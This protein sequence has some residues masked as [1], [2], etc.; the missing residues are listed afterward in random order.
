MK[1][2]GNTVGVLGCGI[3]ICYPPENKNLF[4]RMGEEGAIVTEYMPGEQPLPFHFPERNRIIAGLSKGIL[5]IEASQRSGSL[6]TARLGLEYGREVMAIPGSVFNE[7]YRGANKLIKEGA[8]L[9]D[10]IEDILTT[11]FPGLSFTHEEKVE[12]DGDEKYI[13]ALVGFTKV[14]IDEIIEKSRMEAKK[15]MAA[16]TG[17]EMK[18]VVRQLPGG[19]YIKSSS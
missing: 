4:A 10:G 18:E 12:L 9:V 17:L 11:C 13:Y 6:I 2:G 14:H 1:G 19:F 7:E 15:V 8:K 5:V 3:D 16:M